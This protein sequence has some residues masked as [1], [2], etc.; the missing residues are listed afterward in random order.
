MSESDPHFRYEPDPDHPGWS[1]WA[2]R[3]ETRFNAL[4]GKMLVRQDGDLARVR[5]F[6]ERKHSNLAD[7][8]HGAITLGF[9]DVSLFAAARVFGVLGR[10]PALTLDLSTQFIGAG[11]LDRPLDAEVELLRETGRLLFLRG[12]VHQ[13]DAKV[14]AFAGTIRIQR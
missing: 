14:A 1:T 12:I 2:L 3:D 13:D 5:M 11:Q 10:G 6:P 4:L 9:I 8:V 7:I